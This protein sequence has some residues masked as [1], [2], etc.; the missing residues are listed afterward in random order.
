M[1]VE[2]PRPP[3][4]INSRMELANVLRIEKL[5]NRNRELE[6]PFKTMIEVII[7][8][9]QEKFS[10]PRKGK[11]LVKDAENDNECTSVYV[12]EEIVSLTENS[13]FGII[14]KPD[15]KK[16]VIPLPLDTVK[17]RGDNSHKSTPSTFPEKYISDFQN[18]NSNFKIRRNKSK[19][20]EKYLLSE[21]PGQ[22]VFLFLLE[23][24][25]LMAQAAAYMKCIERTCS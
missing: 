14:Y 8:N 19:N 16:Y 9:L 21:L 23:A 10:V 17:L 20:S 18:A 13:R 2:H 1:D 25:L 12:L 22:Q 6:R 3:D 15:L 24:L 4:S 11:N 5:M 7:Q